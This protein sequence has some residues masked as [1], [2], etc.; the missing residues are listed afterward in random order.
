M[1]NSITPKQEPMLTFCAH[2]L[3]PVTVMADKY[4]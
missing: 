4:L 2:T 1:V 3:N